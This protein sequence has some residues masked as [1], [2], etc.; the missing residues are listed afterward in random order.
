MTFRARASFSTHRN[1][2][3][4][5]LLN[6]PAA[7]NSNPMRR[8][9]KRRPTFSPNEVYFIAVVFFPR[10]AVTV[11]PSAPAVEQRVHY[12][13]ARLFRLFF[14]SA[15]NFSTAARCVPNGMTG[16]R[17]QS[18]ACVHASPRPGR[19]GGAD[20]GQCTIAALSGYL[21]NSRCKLKRSLQ[22][23]RPSES[24]ATGAPAARLGR[25]VRSFSSNFRN[26]AMLTGENA[27][28]R[29]LETAIREKTKTLRF[30]RLSTTSRRL[31]G[32]GATHA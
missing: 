24:D 16:L 19:K 3:P 31:H 10:E 28:R 13:L 20:D 30:V 23:S 1:N 32:I 2:S 5:S 27:S 26:S 4:R 25:V 12:A 29:A 9:P 7:F 15:V 8:F 22:T 18:P 21:A 14:L 17:H 11:L 6:R